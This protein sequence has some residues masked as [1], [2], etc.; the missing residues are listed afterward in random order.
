MNPSMLAED[1]RMWRQRPF[2]L[3]DKMA[4][5]GRRRPY[6]WADKWPSKTLQAV[7][8][9]GQ[10]EGWQADFF[11]VDMFGCTNTALLRLFI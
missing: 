8:R 7:R 5:E 1:P 2:G 3:A 10:T 6:F 9:G 4:P 11:L